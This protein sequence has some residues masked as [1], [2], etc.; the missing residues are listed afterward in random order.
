LEAQLT[1]YR[2]HYE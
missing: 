2:Q 1:E